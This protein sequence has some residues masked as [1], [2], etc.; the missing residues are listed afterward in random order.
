MAVCKEKEDGPYH[1]FIFKFNPSNL[2]HF[3]AD[4]TDY[5]MHRALYNDK[6]F[7]AETALVK[8]ADVIIFRAVVVFLDKWEE[9]ANNKNYTD[10]DKNC[11]SLNGEWDDIKDTADAIGEAHLILTEN[12]EASL[13]ATID[14]QSNRII[15]EKRLQS[16]EILQVTVESFNQR[17]DHLASLCEHRPDLKNFLE[18]IKTLAGMKKLVEKFSAKIADIYAKVY[19][20]SLPKYSE[21]EMFPQDT[22]Q[23]QKDNQ[24]DQSSGKVAPKVYN[25]KFQKK[26]KK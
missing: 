16:L 11:I 1:R 17:F 19:G 13:S 18:E 3:K 9:H 10:K 22:K 7:E 20:S 5:Y 25:V 24:S 12:I 8:K 6:L 26:G 21:K 14:N 2:I 15:F 23:K 4:V